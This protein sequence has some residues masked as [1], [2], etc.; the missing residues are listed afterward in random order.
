MSLQSAI[1]L[2]EEAVAQEVLLELTRQRAE[3]MAVVGAEGWRAELE[4]EVI[5]HLVK[6]GV[7]QEV[8][9][10]DV[11]Q[12]L[13]DDADPQLLLETVVA[14]ARMVDRLGLS[15]QV[16]QAM[17]EGATGTETPGKAAQ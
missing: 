6:A 12:D 13:R 10:S 3:R 4:Q 7:A 11:R 5:Q 1:R 15:D 9:T 2:A 16:R 8:A 14:E 17:E